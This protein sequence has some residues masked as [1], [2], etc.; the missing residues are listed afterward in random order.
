MIE[1]SVRWHSA[2]TYVKIGKYWIPK[3]YTYGEYFIR[4][5]HESI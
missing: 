1:H 2:T 4:T 3:V 5:K